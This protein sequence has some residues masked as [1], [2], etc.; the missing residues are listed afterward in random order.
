[1]PDEPSERARGIARKLLLSGP[2]WRTHEHCCCATCEDRIATA[3]QSEYERGKRETAE[4]C[5]AIA[6]EETEMRAHLADEAREGVGHQHNLLR[7]FGACEARDKIQSEFN[8]TSPK[9]G[10]TKR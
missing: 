5:W 3:L 10:S 6:N 7:A 1:M 8:L 2:V 9:E 4:R